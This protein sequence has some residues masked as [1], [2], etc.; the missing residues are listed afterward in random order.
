MQTFVMNAELQACSFT[1]HCVHEAVLLKYKYVDDVS[2][3]T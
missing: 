1:A 2:N 3:I